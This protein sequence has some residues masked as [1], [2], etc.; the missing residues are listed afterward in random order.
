MNEQYH[1]ILSKILIIILKFKIKILKCNLETY[2]LS[3][4]DYQ[5]IDKLKQLLFELEEIDTKIQ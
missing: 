2:V 3:A 5:Q 1:E 4:K